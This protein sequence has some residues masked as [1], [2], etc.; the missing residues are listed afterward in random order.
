MFNVHCEKA[1]LPPAW[2]KLKSILLEWG[3]EGVKLKKSQW[4]PKLKVIG[5]QEFSDR[6]CLK[7]F[8]NKLIVNPLN[9]RGGTVRPPPVVFF[10]Y[11]K[12]LRATHTWKILTFPNFWLRIPLWIL[13]S[14]IVVYTLR[15][16][17]W[18]TQYK[19]IILFFALIKKS[20]YKT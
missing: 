4:H 20:F 9:D 15:Q 11:S 16:H 6:G 3:Q 12:N 14:K 7:I 13:F 10:L 19:N 2:H 1:P 18:D 5:N 8:W 17:F